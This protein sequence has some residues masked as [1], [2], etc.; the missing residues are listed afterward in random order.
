M[1]LYSVSNKQLMDCFD[2]IQIEEFSSFD[3]VEEMNEPL[4]D[5]KDEKSFHQFLNSNTDF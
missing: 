5:E 3:F 4:F 1:C 2:D